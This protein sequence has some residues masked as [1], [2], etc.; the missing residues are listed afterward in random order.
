MK[1]LPTR[2][3]WIEI[4]CFLFRRNLHSSLPTRGGWIEIEQ[5]KSHIEADAVP[6]HTGRVD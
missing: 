6:P 1:S 5:L 3:G 4:L 2:G